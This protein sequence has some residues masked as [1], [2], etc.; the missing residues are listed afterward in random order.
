MSSNPFT[1]RR[2]IGAMLCFVGLAILA[3][4]TL[5]GLIRT[6]TWTFLGLFAIKTILV[7]LRQSMD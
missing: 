3:T 4:F 1:S 5:D 7:A 6:A 2:F